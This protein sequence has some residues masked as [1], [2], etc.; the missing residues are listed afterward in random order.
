MFYVKVS[1]Q[2][3]T[4]GLQTTETFSWT[5]SGGTFPEIEH[6]TLQ[7]QVQ[8]FWV[9]CMIGYDTVCGVTDHDNYLQPTKQLLGNF[10]KGVQWE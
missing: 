2:T 5:L 10:N 9:S 6:F 4:S 1:L 3:G 8:Y 7:I